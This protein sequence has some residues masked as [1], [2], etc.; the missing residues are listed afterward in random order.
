MKKLHFLYDD[1]K[2]VQADGEW[3]VFNDRDGDARLDALATLAT[4][5]KRLIEIGYKRLNGERLN[6]ADEWYWKSRKK[7]LD[8]RKNGDQL[9]DW[10]KRRI[11][12]LHDGGLSIC[13]IAKAMGRSNLAIMRVLAANN[14]DPWT[15][16]CNPKYAD[17]RSASPR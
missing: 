6:E 11:L 10:E 8:C 1:G 13:K 2:G 12:R 7:K 17:G 16:S 15:K 9:S 3:L 14:R 4:L 5:P